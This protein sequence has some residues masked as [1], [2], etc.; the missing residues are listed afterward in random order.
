MSNVKIVKLDRRNLIKHLFLPARTAR[1]KTD[2][3]ERLYLGISFPL[4]KGFKSEK[5][6]DAPSIHIYACHSQCHGN[7][8]SEQQV[9]K[10]FRVESPIYP[11]HFI[12]NPEFRLLQKTKQTQRS[13]AVSKSV[14]G[15]CLICTIS[16]AG[17]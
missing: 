16:A 1:K 2:A 8:V 15:F 13:E 6:C 12:Y 9:P 17:V 4:K 11:L 14:R 3:T 7:F 5:H 10:C